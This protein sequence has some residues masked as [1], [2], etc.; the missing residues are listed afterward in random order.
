MIYLFI[1]LR[2]ADLT[3]TYIGLTRG[4]VEGNPLQEGLMSLGFW[5]YP[6]NFTV[7]IILYMLIRR[8]KV[9]KLVLS[10]F[11]VLNLLVVLVNLSIIC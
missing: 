3:T 4:A 5:Y 9:G 7:S 10:L 8:L 1:L 2:L 6:L 11:M